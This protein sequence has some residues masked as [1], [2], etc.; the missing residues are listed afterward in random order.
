[1]SGGMDGDNRYRP[2]VQ[3]TLVEA[4]YLRKLEAKVRRLES[5]LAALEGKER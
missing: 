2:S 5:R 1:M 3:M 4:E